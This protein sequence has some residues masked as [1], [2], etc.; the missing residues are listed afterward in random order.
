MSNSGMNDGDAKSGSPSISLIL[1]DDDDFGGDHQEQDEEY[2]FRENCCGDG[3]IGIHRYE[4][5][6][7]LESQRH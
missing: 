5:H 7:E 4:S 3:G 6:L 2:T 1:P